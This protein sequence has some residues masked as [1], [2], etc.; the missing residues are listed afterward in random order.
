MRMFCYISR[1]FF[2]LLVHFKLKLFAMKFVFALL[3]FLVAFEASQAKNEN[4]KQ[5]SNRRTPFFLRK[6]IDLSPSIVGGRPADIADF[7]HHLGLLDITFGGY[8]C[9][10][11]IVNLRHALSAAHC[12][13]METHPRDLTLLGGSTSRLT[14]GLIFS[15]E[16]Y[17]LHPSY[18]WWTLDNDVAVVRVFV[19]FSIVCEESI[20]YLFY[21]E[22]Y[23]VSTHT[24]SSTR[25][26]CHVA[27]KLRYSMLRSLCCRT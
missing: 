1:Q 17:V 10:A 20:P 7:P 27:T 13:E 5:R 18:D 6:R 14:G 24:N 26:T 22:R 3:V 16:D 11:S 9:G 21:L 25:T 12:L 23:S 19:S 15:V 8:I 4:W 2:S